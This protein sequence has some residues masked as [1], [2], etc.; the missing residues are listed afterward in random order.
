MKRDMDL[1][2]AILLSVEEQ[3]VGRA[4]RDLTI[5]GYNAEQISYHNYLIG[6]AG[7]AKTVDVTTRGSSGPSA[8][9][10]HLTWAGHEFLDAARDDT[11][12]SKTKARLGAVGSAVLGVPIGVLTAVLIDETKRRLGLSP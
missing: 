9:V 3:D 2:R 4:P 7:L 8:L 11:I 10:V 1:I 5:D 6:D 12:W